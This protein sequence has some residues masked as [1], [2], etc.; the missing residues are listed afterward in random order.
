MKSPS[1]MSDKILSYRTVLFDF[2]GV[3]CHGRFYEK[4]LLPEHR[5]VRDWLQANVFGDKELVRKW[6]RGQVGSVEVN[7]LIAQNTNIEYGTLARLFEESVVGM[8][9]DKEVLAVAESLK[10]AGRKI[11]LVTDNMDVFTKITVPNHRLDSLFDVIINSADHGV[12]KNEDGGRL[13]DIAL[14]ALGEDVGDSL[15][16][17]DSAATIELFRQKGGQGFV[18]RDAAGL[19]EFLSSRTPF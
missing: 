9:L 3:L 12:L 19:K 15:M 10:R 1:G 8:E 5:E 13:F 16:V 4:A 7:R 17:D 18:Y 2:D 6:M 14:S 11:G